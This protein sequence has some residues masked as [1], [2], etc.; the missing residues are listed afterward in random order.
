[1]PA[2]PAK[3]LRRPC[4]RRRLHVRNSASRF[5][6]QAYI[7]EPIMARASH[8]QI[9]ESLVP[10]S[11]ARCNVAHGRN[12]T[13]KGRSNRVRSAAQAVRFPILFRNAGAREAAGARPARTACRDARPIPRCG[14]SGGA[15]LGPPDRTG[16]CRWPCTNPRRG[17]SRDSGYWRRGSA[18]SA[19]ELLPPN[20]VSSSTMEMKEWSLSAG[21]PCHGQPRQPPHVRAGLSASAGL[22]PDSHMPFSSRGDATRAGRRCG[23][24]D[25]SGGRPC[26]QRGAPLP[27]RTMDAESR[28]PCG[29]ARNSPASARARCRSTSSRRTKY[30]CPAAPLVPSGAVTQSFHQAGSTSAK[31]THSCA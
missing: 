18:R 8:L 7:P 15:N 26:D 4:R 28:G 21:L 30:Q 24:I 16:G 27:R 11:D 29:N 19:D 12:E 2:L 25:C 23:Q 6:D 3:S 1:M 20:E 14:R 10:T 13:K 31:R 17:N 5:P 9:S 22:A